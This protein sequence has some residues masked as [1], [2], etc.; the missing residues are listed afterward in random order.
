MWLGKFLDLEDD[1]TELRDTLEKGLFKNIKKN[2]LTPLEFTILESIFNS[3]EI[4]GYDLIKNLNEH[5]ADT[6]VA[7]SGTIY[8]MLSKLKRDGFL[9]IKNVKSPIGPIKKVYSLTDAGT[10]LLKKKVKD[11]FE[12]QLEFIENFLVELASIYIQS[13][14]EEL[15]GEKITLVQ[16][17]LAKTFKN[18]KVKF[19]LAGFVVKECPS[20]GEAVERKNTK[21]C[22]YCGAELIQEQ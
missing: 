15:K 8:P 4:S 14:P 18:V 2:K 6:W 13:Y 7:R 5:F 1:L 19:P 16:E 12:T 9:N 21:F 22:S 10:S 17:I 20:C 3:K 11:N